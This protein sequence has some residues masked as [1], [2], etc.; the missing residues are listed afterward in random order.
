MS[1]WLNHDWAQIDTI[2]R[3]IATDA[4]QFLAGSSQRRAGAADPAGPLTNLPPDGIGARQATELFWQR[5]GQHL[6]GSVGPRYFGFVTGGVT[7]AALAG[8]WLTGAIDQNAFGSGDSNAAHIELAALQMLRQL[9]N[10][11]DDQHGTFVTGA[12][13]AN[14]VSLAIGRQWVGQQAGVDI[15]AQGIAAAPPIRIFSGTPHASVYK[16]LAMLGIGRDALVEVDTLSGREAVDTT[17]LASALAQWGQPAIVV[18]NAGTVN[19]VD[20]DDLSAILSLRA[21]YPFFLHVD[22]AFGGFAACSPR[23]AALVDGLNDADSITVDAHKYLNVPYDSAMQF[24][25]HVQLQAAVFANSAVYLGEQ[26]TST[27]FINL[28]PENSR[29]LRALPAW[30]TLM[31]YGRAGYRHIVEQS[32]A[33]AATLGQKLS[34]STDFELLAPVRLNGLCFT[35]RQFTPTQADVARFLALLQADG[36]I[37]LTPTQLFG[38][39]AIRLS[40]SNWRTTPTDIDLAYQALHETYERWQE[41]V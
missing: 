28:T 38:Q 34:I 21:Q 2:L 23:Y 10:L 35:F 4:S 7:P 13:M 3:A 33:L 26:A 15:A 14:F 9:L 27:N 18:A 29:R 24:S 16:A 8:D 36:R 12:T 17:A 6:S 20:Y 1:D 40:I 22:G 25:R 32:S 5:Y 37:F 39:P 19:T 11:S 31:A 41:E 30:F